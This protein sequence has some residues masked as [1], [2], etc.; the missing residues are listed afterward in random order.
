MKLEKKTLT[1]EIEMIT[2]KPTIL[3]HEVDKINGW[4]PSVHHLK[5]QSV[6]L[7]IRG[8]TEDLD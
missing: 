3:V 7:F 4:R 8:H 2:N 1:K 6:I 5:D